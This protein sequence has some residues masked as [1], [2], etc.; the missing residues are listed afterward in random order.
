MNLGR[1]FSFISFASVSTFH[2]QRIHS[3]KIVSIFGIFAITFG[4]QNS[5]HLLNRYSN[6]FMV[7]LNQ[8][9]H[10]SNSNNLGTATVSNTIPTTHTGSIEFNHV[11]STGSN[12]SP[13]PSLVES[14]HQRDE[15]ARMTKTTEGAISLPDMISAKV[16]RNKGAVDEWC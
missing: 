4:T 14:E 7:F 2:S 6:C 16:V 3:R 11:L 5:A 13:G 15:R 10:H 12:V 8:R 9:Y 1:Q